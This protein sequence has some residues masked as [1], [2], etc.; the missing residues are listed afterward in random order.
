M[1]FVLSGSVSAVSFLIM[2]V[3]FLSELSAYLRITTTE[4]LVVDTLIGQKIL[5]NFDVTFH[6]LPCAGLFWKSHV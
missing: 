4:H 5:I 6:A 1:N 3:L 2:L